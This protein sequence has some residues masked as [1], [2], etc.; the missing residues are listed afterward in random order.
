MMKRLIALAS[1]K[2]PA[3]VLSVRSTSAACS[4]YGR[5]GFKETKRIENRVGGTSRDATGSANPDSNQVDHVHALNRARNMSGRGRREKTTGSYPR[6]KLV[7]IPG[8]YAICRLE[9]DDT[10]P[11]WA[12]AGRFF[13]SVSRTPAGLSIVCEAQ[14]VPSGVR[15]EN[16]WRALAVEGPLDFSMIGILA[17]VT[18][19]LAAAR[20]SIVAVSTYETDY[21]FVRGQALKRALLALRDAGHQVSTRKHMGSRKAAGR[22]VREAR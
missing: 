17:A 11:P 4:F 13:T 19:P 2:Y 14:G 20:I 12:T 18:A 5:L 9:P 16:G 22:R 10:L 8:V 15:M 6:L 21:V 3:I 1:T 7:V